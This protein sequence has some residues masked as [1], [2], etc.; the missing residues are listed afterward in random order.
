MD[1]I[2][3]F[4]SANEVREL[5]PDGLH[6][7]AFENRLKHIRKRILS[8]AAMDETEIKVKKV[9]NEVSDYLTEKGYNVFKVYKNNKKS[10]VDYYVISWS[11]NDTVNECANCEKICNINIKVN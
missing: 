3:S 9:F 4:P 8:A 11:S 10:E 6:S 2:N 1:I 5:A 7:F